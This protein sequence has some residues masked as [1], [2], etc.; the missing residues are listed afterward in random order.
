MNN[1]GPTDLM[2]GY[3]GFRTDDAAD[4]D[5]VTGS[6]LGV[7]SSSPDVTID[8]TTLSGVSRIRIWGKVE[9]T[10]PFGATSLRGVPMVKI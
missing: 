5:G 3:D 6:I 7:E 4:I 8:K 1:Q 9:S 2:Y 10:Y